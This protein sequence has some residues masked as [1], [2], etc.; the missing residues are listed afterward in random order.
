[1]G[2]VKVSKL[3]AAHLFT[4]LLQWKPQLFI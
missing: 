3:D 4:A 2:I 1:M